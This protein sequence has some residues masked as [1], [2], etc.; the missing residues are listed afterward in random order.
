[1]PR[2]DYTCPACGRLFEDV[3]VPIAVGAIKGAPECPD[4]GRICEWIPAIG[5][6]DAREPFQTFT[7]YDGRNQPVTIDSLHTLRRVERESE[8]LARNG[9]GQPI[10][11][12]R[13]SQDDSNKD[14]NT[15]G[16]VTAERPTAAAARKFGQTLQKSAVA[17]DTAYGPGINDSNASALGGLD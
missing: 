10:R 6:M 7:C 17:P 12:R 8:Q 14:V 2:H 4:C 5:A 13:W 11:F 16:A 3:V 9:E 15:F 1:M